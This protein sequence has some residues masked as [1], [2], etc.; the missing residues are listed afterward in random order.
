MYSK[1][2]EYGRIFY[3]FRIDGKNREIYGDG[4]RDAEWKRKTYDASS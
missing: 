4:A 2:I 3:M 1:F